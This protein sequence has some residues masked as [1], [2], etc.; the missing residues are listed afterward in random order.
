M[1]SQVDISGGQVSGIDSL[2]SAA[3]SIINWEVDEA[4]INRMRA[5]LLSY[6]QTGLASSPVIGAQVWGDYLILVTDNRY[7][8]AI[9]KGAP[10]LVQAL[11]TTTTSTQLEGTK[12]PTFALGTDYIYIAGGGQIQ[13][14]GPSLVTAAILTNSPRCTHIVAIGQR[15]VVNDLD[16]AATRQ[17]FRWSASGEGS[18]T[19]WSA[20][21]VSDA[22]ARPDPVVAIYENIN[23]LLIFGDSTLQVYQVGADPT[24]PF[25]QVST[26]NLGISA[27]YCAAR[28][29]EQ[30]VVLDDKR[31]LVRC[32][33]RTYED[34]SDAIHNDLRNLST[35]SDGWAYRE[36]R[37]Q[38]SLL[39]FRF[40]TDERTFVYDLKGK[41]WSE[42]KY[43]NAPVQDDWRV[44]AYAYWPAFNYHMVGLSSSSGGLARLDKDTRQ[45]LAGP[46]VCER[47]TGWHD[48]GT[49]NSKRSGRVRLVMRRGT[50]SQGSTPG[51]VEIRVQ[52]D[53]SPWSPW[54]QISVG[55]PDDYSQVIELFLG[56]V[57]R[58]R[59]YGIRYSNTDSTSI[60]GMWDEVDDIEAQEEAA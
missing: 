16:T 20:S 28:L 52:D 23:E 41:R 9:N 25:D 59:R 3:S 40:P 56:G 32:D 50:A 47:I 6:T 44:G 8:W 33:G 51:L 27:P 45:D 12:R 35:I 46:L 58:R 21:N 22:D 2:S 7:I 15:L 1:L 38:Q 37:D 34:F 14:W 36:E 4:G 60:V 24:L 31:R 19:T 5:G 26:I 18:W 13:R 39:V 55:S 54:E 57:F 30:F 43:Y 48:Y 11:S 17:Q 42:R 49:T 53:E 10:T 29:D